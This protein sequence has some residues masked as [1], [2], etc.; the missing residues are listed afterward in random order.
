MDISSANQPIVRLVKKISPLKKTSLT[1]R[2]SSSIHPLLIFLCPS[3]PISISLSH[4]VSLCSLSRS[5]LFSLSHIFRISEEVRGSSL[6]PL[7]TH[8]SEKKFFSLSLP[9]SS[10]KK[11]KTGE[12]LRVA[13]KVE[14]GGLIK[15]LVSWMKR[16]NQISRVIQWSHTFNTNC[17][18]CL[19]QMI[20]Y[21]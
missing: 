17:I 15:G 10:R 19:I 7:P 1:S 18:I 21:V 11:N 3:L 8:Q 14:H 12:N 13:K 9:F 6:G 2:G 20:S 16:R 5:L 4:P